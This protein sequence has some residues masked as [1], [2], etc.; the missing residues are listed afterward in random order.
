M[1]SV[2][3][4][5]Q[6]FFRLNYLLVSHFLL[7]LQDISTGTLNGSTPSRPSFVRSDLRQVSSIRFINSIVESFGS[8]LR[9]RLLEDDADGEITNVEDVGTLGVSRNDEELCAP[10]SDS[11][12]ISEEKRS[13]V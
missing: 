3:R 6:S 10:S 13:E 11:A 2:L 4:C 9:D 8:P 12:G 5:L 7:N 1:F